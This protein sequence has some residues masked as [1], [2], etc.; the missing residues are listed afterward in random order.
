M[1]FYDK[2]Y[3]L[4]KPKRKTLL[5]SGFKGYD[6]T[7][8]RSDLPCDY[9]N[10]VYNFRFKNGM[11]VNPYGINELQYGEIKIPVLPKIQ[12]DKRLFLTKMTVEGEIKST[13]VVSYQD[14][15]EYICIGDKEWKHIDCS[16][17]FTSG[18]NYLY[19][20]DDLLILSGEKGIKVFKNGELC[21][22]EYQGQIEALCVHNERIYAIVKGKRNSLWF[23][24]NFDPFNW[25]V[26]IDEGGYINFDGT[27]GD[28]RAIK[29]F[30][31]YLYIFCDYGIYRLTAF[32]DQSQFSMKKVYT[33]CGRIF[34]P[35][36][37]ECGEY[38]A[39]AGEDG[40][41]LFDGYDV[42][43]Y[44]TQ[45]NDLLARGFDDV[46]ACY[47]H[48]KYIL[49]FT[50]AVESNYGV[51]TRERDNNLLLIF[52]L[53]DK[54]V[55]LMRGISFSR[56]TALNMSD[57]NSIIGLSEDSEGIAQL[58]D[59][60]LYFG[61]ALQKY[62]QSGEIDFDAPSKTKV[63][64]SIE[65]TTPYQYILGI[66]ADGERHEFLLSPRENKQN[67]YIKS[68]SFVF[69]IR[70][71]NNHEQIKSPKIQVDFLGS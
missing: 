20:D 21:D 70:S 47:A 58:D 35:S 68:N 5:L 10:C 12:G 34:A 48:N 4:P 11:L 3:A 1:M 44:S 18:V 27:L 8:V 56:L 22:V 55:N 38:I 30:I 13:L 24:D 26:S 39:F 33:S 2:E 54:S 65:Y 43:R 63:L 62:W 16:D 14:G 36:I 66:L 64:R 53:A 60:G 51:F 59:S 46:Y 32:A 28:V 9:V 50:N 42:S 29:S 41:Y 31:N 7:K 45:A 52:D 19:E 23:S 61:K 67:L 15:I 49:S 6:E 71:D 57:Y 40:V 69:Y 17:F 25:N 37:T